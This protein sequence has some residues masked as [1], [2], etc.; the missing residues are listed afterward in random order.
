VIATDVFDPELQSMRNTRWKQVFSESAQ[1]DDPDFLN[2]KA[3][4]VLEH[5]IQASDIVHT[6]QHWTIYQKWNRRLF[7]EMYLAFKAGRTDK[8]PSEGWYAG[9]LWFFDNYVIPLARKLK[10]CQVFGASGHEYQDCAYENR[11]EWEQTGREIV[12]EMK[13]ELDGPFNER[14]NALASNDE[15]E[16]E[17]EC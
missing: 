3:T 4:I 12:E 1:S 13:R 17:M 16:N 7:Q 8:D 6:V 5:V 14:Q 9:E 15:W 11:I 2:R 10:E